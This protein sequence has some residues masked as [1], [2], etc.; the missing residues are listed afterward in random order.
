MSSNFGR[1]CLPL[2]LLATAG[3]LN[4]QTKLVAGSPEAIYVQRLNGNINSMTAGQNAENVEFNAHIAEM[5][6]AQPLAPQHLDSTDVTANVARVMDFATY[7]QRERQW[8][9]SLDHSFLDSMYVLSEDRPANLKVLDAANVETSFRTERTAFNNFLDAMNK[10][11]AD[12]L[13]ALL[14]LQHTHYT[15][16]KDQP[17]FETHDQVKEY[18]Q[19]MGTVDADSK[20]LNAANEALRRANAKANQLTKQKEE[21]SAPNHE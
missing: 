19:L 14:F 20:T 6:A 21:G 11:Y 8:S 18:M 5:N 3:Q 15:I 2:L 12:V 7:L 17:V 4:A 13:D 10:V 9:D 16:R 1:R